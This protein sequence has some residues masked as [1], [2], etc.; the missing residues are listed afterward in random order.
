MSALILKVGSRVK[1]L[2]KVAQKGNPITSVASALVEVAEAAAKYSKVLAEE[3]T[4]REAIEA[5][6]KVATAG[7]RAK[8][9]QTVQKMENS[10]SQ[11]ERAT[12]ICFKSIDAALE[13]EDNDAL[14]IALE[15]LEN[16]IC[17]DVTS[18]YRKFVDSFRNP[19]DVI[20]I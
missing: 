20:E 2:A 8:L 17:V 14:E 15:G 7:I 1:Q 5:A 10:G 18:D 4:K 16:T 19:K 13:S 12:S 11:R 6:R 9:Q 3:T